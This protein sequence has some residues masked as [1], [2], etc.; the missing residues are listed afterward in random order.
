MA[1]RTVPAAPGEPPG[2]SLPRSHRLRKRA[3]IKRVQD[4]GQRFVSGA[5]VLMLS[6]NPSGSRRLGVTVS[7]KV[8][9][10][11]VRSK[12]KRWFREIFR[13]HRALLPAACDVVLIARAPAAQ[14]SLAELTRLFEVAAEKARRRPLAPPRPAEGP[15]R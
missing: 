7:S 2:E 12:I 8:G 5:L 3:Q 1:L 6:P 10:S 9:N 13:K 15:A 4:G 11:V 14:S